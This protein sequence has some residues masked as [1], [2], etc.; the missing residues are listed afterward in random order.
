[1]G[2]AQS[3]FQ[4]G[5]CLPAISNY[6]E[7]HLR[8]YAVCGVIAPIYFALMV[9][10]EGL[11]VRGYSQVSQPISDLGAYV[12]YGS[13]ALLQNLNFWVFSLLVVTFAIGLKHELPSSRAITTSMAVFGAMIFLAGVFPDE[14]SPWPA[15]AHG[16]GFNRSLRFYHPQSIHCV[17]KIASSGRRRGGPLGSL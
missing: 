3:I 17:E 14:P 8:W 16:I 2:H 12:L 11:L 15:G 4:S 10:V 9:I 1:M 7:S 13:Y 5:T 6:P